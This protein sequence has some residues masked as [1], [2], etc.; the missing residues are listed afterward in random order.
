MRPVGFHR[1]G[2]IDTSRELL[3]THNPSPD[4]PAGRPLLVVRVHV[5][6]PLRR[7]ILRVHK[8]GQPAPLL[9]RVALN[10]NIFRGILLVRGLPPPLP[11]PVPL[12]LPLPVPLPLPLPR[13]PLVLVLFLL[14]LL[15]LLLIV[16]KLSAPATPRGPPTLPPPIPSCFSLPPS[17]T[18]IV[19]FFPPL[20]LLVA[21]L[22]ARS[23]PPSPSP[24]STLTRSSGLFLA[25]V[26]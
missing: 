1:P 4:A 7:Q 16:S 26:R 2:V 21:I 13:A 18:R 19:T 6:V 10:P 5:A 14:L 23:P 9:A 24:R 20:F 8:V 11:L 15:F 25:A 22:P 12:P 3:P 17:P